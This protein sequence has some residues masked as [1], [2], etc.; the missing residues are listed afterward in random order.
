MPGSKASS[1]K[2]AAAEKTVADTQTAL[3]QAQAV[4]D[5]YSDPQYSGSVTAAAKLAAQVDLVKA[6]AALADAETKRAKLVASG[7]MD[8]L[9][10]NGTNPSLQAWGPVLFRVVQTGSG[11]GL[12]AVNIQQQFDTI[13]IAPSAPAVAEVTI[14]LVDVSQDKGTTVVKI[15]TSAE[16]KPLLKPAPGLNQGK[17][18]YTKS[19][20]TVTQGV[21]NK[22]LIVTFTPQL[23]AITAAA[24]P[25][26]PTMA[27]I[28]CALISLSSFPDLQTNS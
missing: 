14:Q 26:F 21:D 3:L 10:F 7:S 16:V 13:N 28:I 19:A 2:L 25:P 6:K 17:N 20:G 1:D 15:S 23:P 11:A 12:Q 9:G 27:L 22:S 8:S 24:P 5:L 4:A 18:A